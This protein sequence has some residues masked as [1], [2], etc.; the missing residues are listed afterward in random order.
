VDCTRCHGFLEDHALSLLKKEHE[1]GKKGA[2]RLMKNLRPRTVKS[3]AQ[4][5]GRT[6]WIQ[7]PDCMTCHPG[8]KRADVKTSNAFNVWT[9]KGSELYRHRKEALKGLMCESCHGSTNANYPALNPYSAERDNIQPLQYQGNNKSMGAEGGCRAC[10]TKPPA[11]KP[12]H[13]ANMLRK[14]N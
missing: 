13:H 3:L 2:A 14:T 8:Y 1:A 11:D 12:G 10:H 5:N 4:I 7:E 6:P 9:K